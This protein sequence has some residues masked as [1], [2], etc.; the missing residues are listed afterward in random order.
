MSR[1]RMTKSF[2]T[3]KY[4][5]RLYFLHE[6]AFSARAE[7]AREHIANIEKKVRAKRPFVDK[8]R[9]HT[10]KE[11]FDFISQISWVSQRCGPMS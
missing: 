1:K 2:T 7:N 3:A 10:R 4:S 9:P 6:A 5:L 11:P 8:F